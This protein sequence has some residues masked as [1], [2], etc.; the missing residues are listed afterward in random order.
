MLGDRSYKT[1]T[2]HSAKVLEVA[3]T[4]VE[5]ASIC[6]NHRTISVGT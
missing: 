2:V 6:Q 5:G 3:E 1:T 4:E